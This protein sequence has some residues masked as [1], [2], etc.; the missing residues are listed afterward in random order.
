ME[1][2]AKILQ[3]CRVGMNTVDVINVDIKSIALVHCLLAQWFEVKQIAMSDKN[4]SMTRH[5]QC[6]EQLRA[7]LDDRDNFV[8]RQGLHKRT[9]CLSKHCILHSRIKKVLNIPGMLRTFHNYVLMRQ[10]MQLYYIC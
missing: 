8:A 4:N 5:C 1:M 10:Q 6:S 9:F 3:P 7:I 2:L